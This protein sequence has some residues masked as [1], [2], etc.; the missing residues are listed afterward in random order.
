MARNLSCR[1]IQGSAK[2]RREASRPGREVEGVPAV[3]ADLAKLGVAVDTYAAVLEGLLVG[4]R[5]MGKSSIRDGTSGLS[6][7]LSP[8][9]SCLHS[10]I[11]W[12]LAPKDL[13]VLAAS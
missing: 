1:T 10:L 12:C 8:P 13:D 2:R 5:G 6:M 11:V 7:G 4:A 9:G 3:E